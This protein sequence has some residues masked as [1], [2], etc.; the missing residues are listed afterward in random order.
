MSEYVLSVRHLRKAC[1]GRELFTDLSFALTAGEAAA[2]VGPKGAGKT[3]LVRIL[4]GLVLPEGGELSL[5]GSRTEK[6]LRRA[7]EAVAPTKMPSQVKAA[8]P[9][10]GISKSQN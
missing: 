7:R 2:L 1:G 4:A 3:T 9:M 8:Q 10:G 5:F 6:E